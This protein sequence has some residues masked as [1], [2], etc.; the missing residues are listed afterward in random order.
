[1]VPDPPEPGAADAPRLIRKY[2]NRRL[3][4]TVAGRFATLDDLHDMIKRG[5]D[6]TVWEARTDRDITCSILAQI[7]AEETGKGREP[8]PLDH[9][10]QVLRLY[11]DGFGA[12][13]ASYLEHSMAL[14]AENQR[15]L[16]RGIGNP[17]DPAG[18][19]DAFREMGE[20]NAAFLERAVSGFS[21]RPEAP[22]PEAPG[23]DGGKRGEIAALR[24]QL[25][26][27]QRRL[28]EIEREGKP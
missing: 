5:E 28:D 27:V 24:D 12:Q 11:H 14:F 15:R 25:A 6:F 22:H 26:A 19:L 4:D 2:A 1:M 20:R 16:L 10:R 7:L 18:M 21:G 9:L 3:Y 8:L 13:L 23:A 17:F